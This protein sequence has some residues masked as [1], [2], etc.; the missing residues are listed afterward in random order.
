M[1]VCV[2]VVCLVC[3]AS[4]SEN[5]CCWLDHF[6]SAPIGPSSVDI[7]GAEMVHHISE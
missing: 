5:S 4:L 1:C 6:L 7:V 3:L 2:C